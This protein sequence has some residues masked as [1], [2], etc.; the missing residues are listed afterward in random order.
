VGLLQEINSVIEKKRK[1]QTNKSHGSI[2]VS[3]AEI[4]GGSKDDHKAQTNEGFIVKR[5]RKL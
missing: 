5:T 2:C 3:E 1:K 4:L